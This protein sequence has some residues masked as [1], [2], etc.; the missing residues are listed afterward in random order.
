MTDPAFINDPRRLHAGNVEDWLKGI[1]LSS[2][3]PFTLDAAS[4]RDAS[5]PLVRQGL[6]YITSGSVACIF[7]VPDRYV[8]C[9]I[10][11]LPPNWRPLAMRVEFSP[12]SRP[13]QPSVDVCK[14][15]M[16]RLGSR[17]LPMLCARQ[18][19]VQTG[20]N[21]RKDVYLMP[22]VRKTASALALGD[23]QIEPVSMIMLANEL[24]T[25]ERAQRQQLVLGD[26]KLENTMID[27]DGSVYAIDYL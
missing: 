27:W 19:E 11:D 4:L 6:Y 23:G 12:V 21:M 5:H 8:W 10:G 2:L 15:V 26:R 25:V 9:Q 17:V 16:S 13:M 7:G 1:D 24:Y 20:S 3:D 22:Y 14:Q 18:G